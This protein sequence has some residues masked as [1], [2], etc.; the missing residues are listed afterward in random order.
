MWITSLPGWRLR[1]VSLFSLYCPLV[2]ES[3][4]G[5]GDVVLHRWGGLPV[6]MAAVGLVEVGHVGQGV[7]VIGDGIFVELH[8]QSWPCGQGERIAVYRRSVHQ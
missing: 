3:G 5:I 4:K 6:D 7:R 1:C 2:V 8:A